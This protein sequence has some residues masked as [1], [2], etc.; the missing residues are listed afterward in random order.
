[1]TT[2]AGLRDVAKY[3]DGAGPS[4]DYI[5]PRDP[6]GCSLPPTSFVRD[7]HAAGLQVHPYTSRNEKL[8]RVE[9]GTLR[10]ALPVRGRGDESERRHCFQRAA[11]ATSVVGR[12]RLAGSELL[13]GRSQH[14]A[15]EL[16]EWL[17]A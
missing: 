3:A 13:E 2:P 12:S 8:D 10:V 6:N 1:M 9:G 16:I 14:G 4:K 15:N 7:A 5:V 17:L 11:A